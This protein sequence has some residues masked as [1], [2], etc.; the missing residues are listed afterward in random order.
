[1]VRSMIDIYKE[2][3]WMP[4]WELYGRETWTMEG[5]PAIPIITDLYLKGFRGFDIPAAYEAFYK[6]ATM[7]SSDNLQRPDNAPYVQ[8]GYIPLGYFA[9]D[10]SGDNSVS[11]MPLLM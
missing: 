4:K 11:S 9:A 10:M 7:T 6:S 8:K 1:M 3:G 2:W 5:D